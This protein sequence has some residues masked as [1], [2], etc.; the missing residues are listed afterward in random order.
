MTRKRRKK[1]LY[2]VIGQG[3]L[4]SFQDKALEHVHAE[5]G[6]EEQ[7]L[8][9]DYTEPPAAVSGQWRRRPRIVQF[10][11]SRVE[12]SLPYPLAIAA[13]MGVVLL[14]LV[15]FRLGQVAY[16]REVVF[17]PAQM[18][19]SMATEAGQGGESAVAA[20]KIPRTAE[21]VIST[22]NNQIVIQTWNNRTQLVPVQKYF[23]AKGVATEIR[24]RG[25]M[26]YLVTRNKYQNPQRAGTDG[27]AARERIVELGAKYKAPQGYESFRKVGQKPFND[28]YGMRF[29]D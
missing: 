28:A 10:S 15:V 16:K 9:R 19:E 18:S 2:E 3:R 26:Y 24:H 7:L 8:Q 21:P 17:E 25:D 6:T 23:A 27:Y 11:G 14:F 4:K 12:L 13:L 22:G 1:S 20:K 29:S 5:K